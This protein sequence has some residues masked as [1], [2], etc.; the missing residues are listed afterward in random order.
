M[1]E[2]GI[3]GACILNEEL[4]R[5]GALWAGY[6]ATLIGATTQIV[7]HGNE[8]QKQRWLPKLGKGEFLG[9]ITMTEPY[10][11]SDIAAIETTGILEGD[12]YVVNGIKRYQTA[13]GAGDLYMT[14]VKTSDDPAQRNKNRHLTGMIV[15]KGMPGFSVEKVNDWMGSGGMYNCYLRLIN[16]KV[17][18]KNVI[19]GEGEGWRVMMSGLNAE[20]I[21]AAASYLGMMR[22][23]IRYARQHLE[24]RIQFGQT[25]GSFG[26]NQFKLADMYSGLY[27]AS[28]IIYYAAYCSDLGQDVP[29]EAAIAKLFGSEVLLNTALE[30]I[31]CMGGNGAMQIY[32][33][34]RIMRDAKINQIAAGTSEVLRLLIYRMGNRYLAKDMRVPIRIIDDK[35]N[36][37]ISIGKPPTAK[38]VN[39]ENDVLKILAENYRVNPGLHMT[40]GDI[41][42]QLD[43]GNQELIANLMS[44]EEKELVG[45]YRDKRKII[46]LAKATFKGLAQANPPDYYRHIPSWV[47]KKDIF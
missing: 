5:A 12:H 11:G 40:L 37:P 1:E 27:L 46:T 24:R 43:I 2:W 31:Q 26:T 21:I 16:V 25:I 15:E 38:R 17:P 18:V 33:V 35:L 45:L 44:L 14:Y 8:E 6:A 13:A 47:D 20:R 42:E 19:G 4:S 29:V 32:P 28:L 36:I 7:H 3:T 39:D 30:A 9:S 34:E 10:A 41:Q 23:S 22:E